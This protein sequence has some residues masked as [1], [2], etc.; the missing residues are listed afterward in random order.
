[1]DEKLKK[2]FSSNLKRLL[3]S[4]GK[5]Q[6]DMVKYMNISSA[7]ASDW[8]NG[9]KIPRADKLQS[10]C[11]WLSCDLDS[12]MG[13]GVFC[14]EMHEHFNNDVFAWI[15]SDY[16]YDAYE[17]FFKFIELPKTKQE[18]ILNYIRFLAAEDNLDEYMLND[19]ELSYMVDYQIG[20]RTQK[21]SATKENAK[22]SVD[23]M[24]S[25]ESKY[26]ML[27]KKHQSSEDTNDNK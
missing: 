25:I 19:N 8:C 15:Y 24:R 27:E 23:V 13:T 12:L 16:G 26:T 11:S 3:S 21:W 6:A 20:Y 5:T 2:V 18:A 10:L 4:R 9:K 22:F 17:V 14:D 7:T 1:M